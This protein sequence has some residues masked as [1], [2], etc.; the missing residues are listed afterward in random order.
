MTCKQ[1][2]TLQNQANMVT[3]L[4]LQK[5]IFDTNNRQGKFSPWMSFSMVVEVRANCQLSRK[6]KHSLTYFPLYWLLNR[7]PEMVE[8]KNITKKKTGQSNPL[9]TLKKQK[10]FFSLLN[11]SLVL[12]QWHIDGRLEMAA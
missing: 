10:P 2:L 8:K 4:F 3:N 11:L 12:L 6:K 7:D 5:N 9:S 1:F